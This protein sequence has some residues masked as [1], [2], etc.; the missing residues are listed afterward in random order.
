MADTDPSTVPP[1]TTPPTRG[2]GGRG[3]PLTLFALPATLLAAILAAA[4]ITPG[5]E[6]CGGP[7]PGCGSLRNTGTLPVTIRVTDAGGDA[8]TF[9]LAPADRA[10]LTGRTNAVALDPGH[11]LTLEGGPFWTATTTLA[12][13]S[14]GRRWVPIDDWGSRVQLREGNCSEE[15]RHAG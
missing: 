1:L 10:L 2:R 8:T 14:D 11:C 9:T 6:D 4:F 13:N 5:R 12:A 3:H 7:V 15:S